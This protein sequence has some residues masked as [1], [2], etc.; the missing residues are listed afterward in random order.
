MILSM[1]VAAAENGVIGRD[2]S[3]VWHLSS[4]LKHFKAITSGHTVIMGRR[5]FESIGRALPKRR[6]IVVSRNNLYQAEG[7]EV[8]TS[9]EEALYMV[10]DEDEV[11]VTGGG[12]IYREVWNLADKL[13]L[14]V[15][16]THVEG[17][18]FIPKIDSAIW[19]E[20]SKLDCAASDKDDFDYSFIDY[21]REK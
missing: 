4:D 14:T 21:I 1:I 8:A 18:T 20:V 2:N 15:V 17:D 12:S 19:K 10:Q 6:N 11:F 9:V 13:Y 5:T 16:H 7:C 3:L